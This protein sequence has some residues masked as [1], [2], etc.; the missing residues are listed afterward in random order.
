MLHRLVFALC[1]LFVAVPVAAQNVVDQDLVK[2][3]TD[4][5]TMNERAR[6]DAI[7]RLAARNK[8]DIAAP[9]I[10]LLPFV[11]QESH[12]I[13]EILRAVTGAQLKAEWFEWMLWQEA[14]PQIR[15]FPGYDA[16]KARF[17]GQLDLE[18]VRFVYPGVASNIRLEEI[19]WSGQKFGAVPALTHPKYI[20]AGEATWLQD[21]QLVFGISIGGEARAYPFRIMEF[22][23]VVNDVVGGV[24]VTLSFCVL[25]FSATLYESLP[26]GRVLPFEFAPSGLVYR[27]TN[28]IFDR[29]S[30]SLWDPLEG[31]PLLGKLA[32][33]GIE[34]KMRPLEFTT[35]K[36]WRTAHPDTKVLSLDTGH[37]RGYLTAEPYIDYYLAK[38][39]FFPAVMNDWSRQPKDVVFGLRVDGAASSWPL[40]DFAGRK[41]VN[42]KVGSV[43]VVLIG[44]EAS[45]DIRAYRRD[46]LEFSAGPIAQELIAGGKTWKIA[47]DAL[48][49]PSNE[50]LDRL[51]G[52]LAFW[53][54]WQSH[55][56]AAK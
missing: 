15:P 42:D 31:K 16:V 50:R 22:H 19:A 8:P 20:A 46:A 39:M 52:M 48:I 17:L 24:P 44:D 21:D 2:S 37:Q 12:R 40:K 3:A 18:F 28:L 35:W 11:P 14:N 47:E 34:L 7:D 29:Q 56:P 1:F 13:R 33:S 49:G 10:D 9:L 32:G 5:F 41:I 30:E 55:F 25:C 54:A 51:P 27:S 43:P 23:E 45:R 26:H 4:M 36:T 6:A 53:F 38:E